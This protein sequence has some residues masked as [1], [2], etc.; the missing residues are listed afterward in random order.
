MMPT[1]PSL[2]TSSEKEPAMADEVS[3][4]GVF[5]DTKTG[6]VT[7]SQPEEGIQLV[8]PGSPVTPDAQRAIDNAKA[9]AGAGATDVVDLSAKD[10]EQGSTAPASVPAEPTRTAARRR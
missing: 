5:I 1:P 3:K 10:A 7:E 8:A 9:A 4:S 6:K 2:F